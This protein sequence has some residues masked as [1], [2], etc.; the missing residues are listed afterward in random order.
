MSR[1]VMPGAE[2][3]AD[4]TQGTA[5]ARGAALNTLALVA[6]NLRGLFTLLIARLLGDAALGTFGVAWAVVDLASKGGTLGLDYRLTA[7]IAATEAKGERA[8]S[9]HLFR[10][11]SRVCVVAGLAVAVVGASLAAASTR[12]TAVQPDL[13]WTIAVLFLAVPGLSVYRVSNAASRGMRALRHDIY[14]RGLT[15]SLVSAGALLVLACLGVGV[16]AAALAAVAGALASGTVAWRLA[17]R[18]F[19]PGPPTGVRAQRGWLRDSMPV[20]AYDFLNSAI[21][22]LDVILLGLFIGRAPE[23]TLQTV[24]IYAAAVEIAGGLR[25][26]SQ[27]FTPIF[28]PVL[29]EHLAAGR[30]REA[31]ES[32]AYVARWMLA[33]LLPAVAVIALSGGAVLSV[34]GP[35]FRRGAPW[36]TLA[37]A[38]CA[39]NAFVG[40]GETILLVARPRW[41]MVNAAVACLAALILNVWLIPRYG[42]LGAAIGMLAPYVLQ[43]VLRGVAVVRVLDWQWPW[44]PLRRPWLAA[45]VALPLGLLVRTVASGL[46]AEIGAGA[47]YV[48]AYACAWYRLGLEPADR[49]ILERLRKR[50]VLP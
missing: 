32:Y 2:E 13:A 28:T 44:R 33:I 23:V 8:T 48:L 20:A 43:G 38:A 39:L 14:S 37:A 22:R 31:E 18:L 15:E 1:P 30:V 26:V 36:L 17:R 49:A 16:S 41:N 19:A 7:L 46:G 4:A 27:A 50:P 29:A 40:L 35:S 5:L 45:L 21:M 3:V 25:K 6:S 42:P 10:E 11:A 34:F 12:L 24:G 47:L 9:H